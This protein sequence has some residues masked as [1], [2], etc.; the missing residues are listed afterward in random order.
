VAVGG[1][2]DPGYPDNWLAM[3]SGTDR[4]ARFE[5]LFAAHYWAVRAYALRRVG[6]SLAED[7][8][9]DTFL[10]AWR[11]LDHVPD[12]ALPWLFGVARRVIANHL[13]GERRHGELIN[14]LKNVIPSSSALW[15]PPISVDHE[16][17]VVLG[18]LSER[19]REA[20]LLVAWDGLDPARAARAAG[21]TAVAFR[22]RLHRARRRIVALLAEKS[23]GTSHIKL[24]EKTP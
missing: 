20:L 7:V 4:R 12:D 11:R 24:K 9:A 17:A 18:S 13:R 3:V 15:E 19:E 22:A 2:T 16:L 14:R 8:L 23:S 1:V 6:A 5:A 10:V 21:C